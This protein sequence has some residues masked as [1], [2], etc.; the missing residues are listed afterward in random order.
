MMNILNLGAPAAA[1]GANMMDKVQ[2]GAAAAKGQGGFAAMLAQIMAGD[3]ATP[4]AGGVKLGKLADILAK[5]RATAQDSLAEAFPDGVIVPG[6]VLNDWAKTMLAKLDGMLEQAGLTMGDL[7]QVLAPLDANLLADALPEEAGAMLTRAARVLV[8]GTGQTVAAPTT[9]GTPAAT[10]EIAAATVDPAL[11]EVAAAP[12]AEAGTAGARVTDLKARID[13]AL[14]SQTVTGALADAAPADPAQALQTA[15]LPDALRLILAQAMA[16][17]ADKT[18]PP[19]VQA[20]LSAPQP[21]A[22]PLI[23][24]VAETAPPTPQQQAPS[25]QHGLARNLAGQIRGVNFSEGTTRI[26][27]TPQ[28]LGTIEIEISPDEQG[29]LRVV[30]RAENPAVLNA[31]RS[32]RDM[33]AG[34]LRDGGTS[35]DDSAMSFEDFGQQRRAAGQETAEAVNSRLTLDDGEVDEVAEPVQSQNPVVDGRLNILT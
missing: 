27:L 4:E 5:F 3:G 2:T 34:L 35:V 16:A 14:K 26:E 15:P 7:T 1:K 25:P 24:S 23:A 17:P 30:L 13:A 19:E 20:I 8:Q 33:L 21:T 29:K 10:P 6:P 32:D 18:L 31:M 11:P 9:T 12:L 28:G 22:A